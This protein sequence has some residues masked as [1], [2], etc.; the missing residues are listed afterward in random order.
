MA[1]G[2]I[3]QSVRKQKANPGPSTGRIASLVN[4]GS[5]SDG[6]G[7]VIPATRS[8]GAENVI[9]RSPVA[10]ISWTECKHL[11]KTGGFNRCKQFVCICK[12]DA[13]PKKFRTR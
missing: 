11:M 1:F 10:S 2:S 9:P 8:S 12:E 13:C 4:D 7:S 5:S 3:L 6:A